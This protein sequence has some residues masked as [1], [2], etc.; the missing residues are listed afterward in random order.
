[1]HFCSRRYPCIYT[2]THEKVFDGFEQVNQ[3]TVIEADAFGG[4]I[5]FDVTT[6]PTHA[7]GEE[8]LHT[9]N[10]IARPASIAFPG[11]YGCKDSSGGWKNVVNTS[12]RTMPIVS[13]KE[14]AVE[15]ANN[16]V[17]VLSIESMARSVPRRSLDARAS[18]LSIAMIGSAD[19]RIRICSVSGC[20]AKIMPVACW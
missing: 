8:R 4:L 14:A 15:R 1:M 7:G 16:I 10:R 3:C 2:D 12:L 20:S 18:C 6:I 11:G 5:D 17:T 19:W 9:S 13:P